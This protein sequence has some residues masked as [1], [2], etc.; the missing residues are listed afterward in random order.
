M[1]WQP[2]CARP[3]TI[4]DPGGLAVDPTRG[5]VYVT[6]VSGT[7][8]T[9]AYTVSGQSVRTDSYGAAGTI[10]FPQGIAVDPVHGQ[11]A[12]AGTTYPLGSNASLM[13]TLG[14]PPAT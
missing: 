1:L 12:I 9:V 10:S 3:S 14:Y 2:R 11:V 13:L 5:L 7:I 8:A 4:D 6:G